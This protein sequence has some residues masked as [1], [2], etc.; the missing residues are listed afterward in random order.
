M[1]LVVVEVFDVDD[2]VVDVTLVDVV[3]VEVFWA[4]RYGTSRQ[5]R[6]RMLQPHGTSQRQALEAADMIMLMRSCWS[7]LPEDSMALL[8]QSRLMATTMVDDLA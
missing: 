8:G 7:P 4:Q 1:E 2:V 6:K 3:V 5:E